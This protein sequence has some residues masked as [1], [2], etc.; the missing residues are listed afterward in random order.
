[1]IRLLSA[2]YDWNSSSPCGPMD[3]LVFSDPAMVPEPS[4][5]LLC[6]V[7]AIPCVFIRGKCLPMSDSLTGAFASRA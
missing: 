4:M 6:G 3:H 7:V 2:D 1:M 5:A